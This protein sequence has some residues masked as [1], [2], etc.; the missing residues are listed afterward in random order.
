MSAET[1]LL[2]RGWREGERRTL[3][4]IRL[5]RR[6]QQGRTHIPTGRSASSTGA[7]LRK[8][9]GFLTRFA[10]LL[11][12]RQARRALYGYTSSQDSEKDSTRGTQ[13]PN[14]KNDR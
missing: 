7:F 10:I 1:G 2:R 13:H 5:R 3:P 11:L 6:G 4:V 8:V 14:P 12:E 9:N